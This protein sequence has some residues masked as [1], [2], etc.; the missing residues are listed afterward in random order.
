MGD[1][2]APR[3]R[4][5]HP[6]ARSDGASRTAYLE[7]RATLFK[8]RKF[9]L[10]VVISAGFLALFFYQVDL[11]Q[12]A[13]ALKKANYWWFIPAIAAYFVA[14][15]FRSMRWHYLLQPIK[16]VPGTRLYPIVVIGY[17]ANTLL[18]VRLGELVRAFFVGQK[19]GVSK[20]AALA[21]IILERLFDGVF[22]LVMALVIWPFL[23]VANLLR[24]LSERSGIPQ[25]G[26]VAI[27]S[28]PF[29]VILAVFFAVAF[30]PRLGRKLVRAILL[31]LP[32]RAKGPAEKLVSGF[33]DGLASLRSPKRVL[34]VVLFTVPVW[35][36]EGFMYY[37]ISLGFH[38]GQAF[39]G[40]LLSTSTSNLATSLPSSAGGVG[41]FEY[42][43]RVTLEQ[44]GTS[45][46]LAAAYAIAL[47]VA[48]LAPVTLLGLFFLWRENISLGEVTRRS[49]AGEG[50]AT[51][52]KAGA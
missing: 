26:L 17:M 18:P 47:H 50:P 49:G 31:L 16:S 48:L 5:C 43:T 39:H 11:R 36:A 51:G 33:L 45:G 4:L 22:L 25:A 46:E 21:T 7:T 10:G 35:M 12:T 28:A 30:S 6:D 3:A 1:L 38:I 8:S 2:Q 32:K 14:V 20:S 24:D 40:I 29:I 23:P 15:L 42:T 37:L 34:A 41:P 44:L 27:V 52:P 13:D 9:W 19:E